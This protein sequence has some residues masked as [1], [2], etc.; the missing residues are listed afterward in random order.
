MGAAASVEDNGIESLA[1]LFDRHYLNDIAD[2][3]RSQ[4]IT[5]GQLRPA[6]QSG[7]TLITFF[8]QRNC[9]LSKPQADKILKLST[10]PE[11]FSRGEESKK[12]AGSPTT[13]EGGG[14][15]GGGADADAGSGSTKDLESKLEKLNAEMN[16]VATYNDSQQVL[17]RWCREALADGN[18]ELTQA[19]IQQNSVLMPYMNDDVAITLYVETVEGGGTPET[20]QQL[21]ELVKGETKMTEALEAKVTEAIGRNNKA[22]ARTLSLAI[23]DVSVRDRLNKDI[24]TEDV[25][26]KMREAVQ[27]GDFAAATAI[28]ERG[29]VA[30]HVVEELIEEA[31]LGATAA[32]EYKR[33]EAGLAHFPEERVAAVATR[34]LG[35]CGEDTSLFKV[36]LGYA[37]DKNSSEDEKVC[38]QLCVTHAPLACTIHAH[39]LALL[40]VSLGAPSE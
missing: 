27:R 39:T 14:G 36:L 16:S 40:R 33:V 2:V 8:A 18:I 5:M 7:K 11:L 22:L 30:M 15:G 24:D 10:N 23:R 13:A 21:L 34:A 12:Q 28:A 25:T 35:S 9:D 37:V 3:V 32:G 6:L 4:H 19:F 20:G 26:P 17:L 31:V 38:V 29:D 1:T